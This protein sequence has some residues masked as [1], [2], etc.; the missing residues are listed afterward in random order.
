MYS[1]CECLNGSHRSGDAEQNRRA[2][3][4]HVPAPSLRRSILQLPIGQTRVL[5]SSLQLLI[6]RGG[7]GAV[8]AGLPALSL[9]MGE[10]PTICL[11]GLKRASQMAVCNSFHSLEARLARCLPDFMQCTMF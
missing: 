2:I 10:L 9:G 7:S 6:T 5:L 4:K 3:L 8:V 1:F 11:V